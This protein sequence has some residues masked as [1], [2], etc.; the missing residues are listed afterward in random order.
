MTDQIINFFHLLATTIWIGGIMYLHFVLF[1][2]LKHIDPQQSGKL[3]GLIA[4][5][6]SIIAW[7]CIVVLLITGYLKTPD[8][9]LFD[10]SSDMGVTL[11]VKHIFIIGMIA[12]GLTI[13]LYIVPNMQKAAPT[14]GSAPQPA[15]FKQQKNLK[16]FAMINLIL[17]ILVIACA[18]M[19]W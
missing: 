6:F 10:S 7:S 18:S 3:Q 5:R 13:T 4:K 12:A 9:F 16:T 1:P 15:F 19:L 11:M 8:G 2:A 14:P 17:G